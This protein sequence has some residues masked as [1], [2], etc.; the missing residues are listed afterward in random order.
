MPDWGRILATTGTLLQGMSDTAVINNWLRMDDDG[1]FASIVTQ[2]RSSPTTDVDRLDAVLLSLTATN[3][4][5][6]TRRRL[7]KFYTIF[8]IAE[9]ERYQEFR[10]FP[11]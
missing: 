6:D 1:A 3:F 2:V 7:I 5:V 11:A 9:F 10:G 8:K 4:D